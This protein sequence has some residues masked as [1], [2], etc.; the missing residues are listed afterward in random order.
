MSP[1]KLVLGGLALAFALAYC[2]PS[3][4]DPEGVASEPK[5]PRPA[6]PGGTAPAG[7]AKPA[8]VDFGHAR[9]FGL[10]LGVLGGMRMVFRYSD[11]SAWCQ[12]PS[13][14]E[15]EPQKFC[16]HQAPYALDGG[17]SFALA[18][19]LEPFLWGR[20]G[21]SR[22]RQ[23]DTDPVR[24]LGAGIRI[25]SMSDARLKVYFEPAVGWELEGGGRSP[26]YQGFAYENDLAFHLG[27]GL[28]V[29]VHENVGAFLSFGMTTTVIRSL[30]S[31][32]GVQLGLQ[33]LA[34]ALL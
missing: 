16:G 29:E 18:D 17:L 6:L 26:A 12:E 10:R 3:Q 23:T 25:Y 1:G 2:R 8:P 28:Q 24:L 31:H 14:D 32:L 4:A 22:E 19:K 21:F 13:K 7:E 9:R 15:G 30:G 20:F 33:G 27:G 11:A 34:P 5:A